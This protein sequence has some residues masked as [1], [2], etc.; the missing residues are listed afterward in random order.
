MNRRTFTKSLGLSIG[1]HGP[2]G[3]AG[4][5]ACTAY[6]VF[7]HDGRFPWR[8]PVML[9]AKERNEAILTTLDSYK[10]KAAFFVIGR[11]I[12]NDEGKELLA[13]WGQGRSHDR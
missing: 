11:N 5:R 6:T 9:T 4:D 12:D 3:S 2:R 7:D 8:N 1:G 13:P 10:T